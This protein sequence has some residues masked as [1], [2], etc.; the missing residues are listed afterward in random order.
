MRI[1]LT[2]IALLIATLTQGA[3]LKADWSEPTH[4]NKATPNYNEFF[5]QEKVHR[6][7]VKIENIDWVESYVNLQNSL[8]NNSSPRGATNTD[9][10]FTPMWIPCTI[11]Y[12]GKQ[13]HKVGFRFKGNSSLQRSIMEGSIKTSFKLDFDQYEKKYS[14][15]KNQRFYGF[16]QLNFNSNFDDVSLMRER[17]CSELYSRFGV[18]VAKTCFCEVYLNYGQGEKYCGIYTIIEELDDTGIKNLFG[19]DS[20]NLYKPQAQAGSFASGTFKSTEFNLKSTLSDKAYTDVRM[21]Y[22][23]LHDKNR[24]KN[25]ELWKKKIEQIFDVNTFLRWLAANHAMQ[26]WDTYGNMPHNYYLYNNPQNSLLTWMPW[27]NNEA[28]NVGKGT[29]EVY[30][31]T[32]ISNKWPLI[33]YIFQIK[34]WEELYKQHLKE[35]A[36]DVFTVENMHTLYDK[37][38]ALL[39][40]YALKEPT[41]N[42]QQPG[43][44]GAQGAPGLDMQRQG[45]PGPGMQGPGGFEEAGM[46]PGPRGGPENF[47][48]M[49]HTF[50]DAVEYLKHQVI[51]RQEVISNYLK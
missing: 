34:E 26:N 24:K 39:K 14:E 41:A 31:M 4:S 18:K 17:I 11:T 6:I 46:P 16:K 25:P 20:G 22:Q 3:N 19:D 2:I 32:E 23:V 40:D 30:E 43:G 15:L 37:Y 29:W 33:N 8:Q 50:E 28:L 51:D 10:T 12:K 49:P 42:R 13:W 45:R 1:K 47:G 7:D 35:F 36:N 38:H 48:G 44:F 5:T 21:L 27:D 9:I